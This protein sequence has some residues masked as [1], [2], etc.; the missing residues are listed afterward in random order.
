[1][2]AAVKAEARYYV[3]MLQHLLAHLAE[4]VLV[5]ILLTF[6]RLDVVFFT[7]EVDSRHVPGDECVDYW[8]NAH[9]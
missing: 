2:T 3:R 7:Q 1:M 4:A 6:A 9:E 5:C 8:Y